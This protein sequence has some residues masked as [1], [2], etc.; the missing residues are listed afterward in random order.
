VVER[1]AAE[2]VVAEVERLAEPPEAVLAGVEAAPEARRPAAEG[3]VAKAELAAVLAEVKVVPAG[4]PVEEPA[5]ER[6]AMEAF[7]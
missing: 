1:L 7:R 4:E 3:L 5:A 6:A 2:P